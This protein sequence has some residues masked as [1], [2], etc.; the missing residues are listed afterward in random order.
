MSFAAITLSVYFVI[1]SV[2]KLFGYTLV[3]C[4]GDQ[5]KLLVPHLMAVVLT[6]YKCILLHL[7][8]SIWLSITVSLKFVLFY[9]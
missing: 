1:D 4:I 5:A 6:L 3:F 2:R 8:P 7:T 9:Y